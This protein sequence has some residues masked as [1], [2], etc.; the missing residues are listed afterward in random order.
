MGACSDDSLLVSSAM[1]HERGTYDNV[2][3]FVNVDYAAGRVNNGY[4]TD[5]TF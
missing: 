3:S 4:G 5:S 1:Q 2:D